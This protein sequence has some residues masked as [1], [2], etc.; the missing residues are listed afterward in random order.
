MNNWNQSVD[1]LLDKIR[2]NSLMLASKHINKHLFYFN[3]SKYFEIPVIILSLFS[4]F[5]SVGS[6]NFIH[7]E[8][9]SAVTCTI[10]MLVTI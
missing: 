5:F 8:T 7:Q 1:S 9:I 6:E 10:S 3:S 2:L 4:S